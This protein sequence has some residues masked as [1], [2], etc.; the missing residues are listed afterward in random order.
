[1]AGFIP[2]VEITD[3]RDSLRV[4]RPDGEIGSRLAAIVDRMSAEFFVQVEVAA[5]IE[6]VAIV[7]G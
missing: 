3:D 1:M 6:Q 5:F 2:A 7:V 4:G